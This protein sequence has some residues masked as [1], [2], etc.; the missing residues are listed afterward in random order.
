MNVWKCVGG[1]AAP[2]VCGAGATDDLVGRAQESARL[3]R[4]LTEH[5]LV[6]VTGRAG[7][8]KSRLAAAVGARGPWRQ[9]VHVH[10]QGECSGAPGTLA[11]AVRRALTGQRPQGDFADLV[12]ELP[13]TGVLLLLDDV[14][15]VQRA[16][17]GLVQRLL[18]AV[19]GLRVLVTSRQ[20]LG[21]GEEQVLRLPPLAA[22][23]GV[24]LFLRRAR[25]AVDGFRAEGAD[26]RAVERICRSLEGVPLALELAAEQLAFQQVHDL[27]A[28]LEVHQCWLHGEG[29]ALR[30]HRS[31]RATVGASYALCER[32]ARIVWGR[33]SVFTGAFDESTASFLCGGGGVAPRQVPSLLARL[34]AINVLEPVRDPGGPRPP[35]Y[36][37]TRAARD[38]GTERL[39][40]A[41]ECETAQERRAT[42]SRRIADT[43]RHLWATGLQSQAVA[44]V[45][46][47]REE[48][49]AVLNQAVHRPDRSVTA[50]ETVVG[51]WFWWVV[52][53][54]AEEGRDYLLRL[55]PLCPADNPVN[56]RGRWLAAWLTAGR[57]PQAAR[58]LLGR[59]WPQA[60]L[61]GD[62]TAVGHIAHVQ[63]LIALHENDPRGAVE[64]FAES[65]RTVPSRPEYGPSPAVS[66]AAQAVA[67]ATFAP[68]AA[69]R[70]A[71]R[72]L[73]RPDVR[74]D[75]WATLLARYATA[76]VDHRQGR[77]T[78]ALHRARRTLTALDGAPAVPH[79]HEALRALIAD[80]EAGVPGRPHLPQLP[81][82]RTAAARAYPAEVGPSVVTS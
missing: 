13:A 57:D 31:L 11:R 60:V 45:H 64:H 12:R 18:A 70:T 5:R 72:A 20:A 54:H 53:G 75:D 43:A 76:Y 21:L 80:I 46:E 69:R 17:M 34:A 66:L 8:G 52:Y 40:A 23:P 32:A 14:D 47:E 78:R 27:A 63:G 6:T 24:E 48:L 68:G 9:I 49:T 82:P 67:Q 51:L 59:A 29:P 58:A 26:Q 1:S 33:A 56:V 77:D 65:A 4:L 79:G 74:D 10:G 61:A 15:P 35:R 30:R 16:A 37:M 22:G 36:R 3:E 73:A 50:L 44:L 25:A 19:P 71:R 39:R 55:L 62:D 41:G 28:V 42:H 81:R 38:F 2:G 7:V